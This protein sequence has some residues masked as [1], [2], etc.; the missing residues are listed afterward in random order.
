[1]NIEVHMSKST[2]LIQEE[3]GDPVIRSATP[4]N[5]TVVLPAFNE[6]VAI[7]SIV[8]LTKHYCDT[9][10][11][12]DDGQLNSVENNDY[13]TLACSTTRSNTDKLSSPSFTFYFNLNL[14]KLVKNRN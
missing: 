1:M 14:L 4:Q 7:G 11:V 12:V 5:I 8:L 2:Q 9:V 6:E 13:E 10:I 3:Q